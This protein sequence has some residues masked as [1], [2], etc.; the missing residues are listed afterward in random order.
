MRYNDYS[1]S[2]ELLDVQLIKGTFIKFKKSH[3][4]FCI[5]ANVSGL[6]SFLKILNHL[7]EK[8][9]NFIR[10]LDL[11]YND[12]FTNHPDCFFDDE[13]IPLE[14]EKIN[15]RNLQ[16]SIHFYHDELYKDYIRICLSR[17]MIKNMSFKLKKII[18]DIETQKMTFTLFDNKNKKEYLFEIKK[19]NQNAIRIY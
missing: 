18:N 19:T 11:K 2:K 15:G 5:I 1:N 14:I 12:S 8:K 10:L 13:S 7:L 17:M 3:D 16:M 6:K 9:Y 4:G